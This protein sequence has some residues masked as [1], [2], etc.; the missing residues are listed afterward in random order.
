M[1]LEKGCQ[2][3]SISRDSSDTKVLCSSILHRR[4][5]IIAICQSGFDN[6]LGSAQLE[7]RDT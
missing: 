1:R 7:V 5:P 2:T 3:F 6:A 4:V